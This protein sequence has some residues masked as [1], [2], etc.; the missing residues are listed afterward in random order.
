[1]YNI[2]SRV[3]ADRKVLYIR[4]ICPRLCK[5]NLLNLAVARRKFG[6]PFRDAYED[7]SEIHGQMTH[8]NIL[9]HI[10]LQRNNR[11]GVNIR[12]KS[13][14]YPDYLYRYTGV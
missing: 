12:V 4:S 8:I 13:G 10:I 11:F 6:H 7:E 5:S 9:Y 2:I 1:M 3:S 14:L